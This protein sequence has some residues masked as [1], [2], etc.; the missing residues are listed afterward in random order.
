MQPS[1]WIAV[2]QII[3]INV[4]LSGDNAVVIALA[5]LTLPP[6][7]RMWGMIL[8]AGVAGAPGLIFTGIVAQIMTMPFL[9]LAGGV[10]LLWIAVKLVYEDQTQGDDKVEGGETVGGGAGV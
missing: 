9:K 2:G 10:A 8:G 4:L 1:F 6:R 3:W 7:Q 5:C